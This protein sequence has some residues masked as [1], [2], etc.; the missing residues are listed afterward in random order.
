MARCFHCGGPMMVVGPGT[1]RRQRRF[2]A[3]AYHKKRGSS[4][5]KNSMLA[6]QD[7]LD[8]VVLKALADVLHEK[9]LDQAIE[10]ALIQMRNQHTTHLDR[11]TEIQRELSLIEATEK[12]LVDAIA[13]GEEMIPLL[14][15]LKAEQTRKNDLVA[16]LNRLTMPA[17]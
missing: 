2:Y 5:C 16:E 6:E 4:I 14:A 1:S 15:K 11:R 12:R 13:K 10:Q 3:C 17:D 9:V 8:N 7:M